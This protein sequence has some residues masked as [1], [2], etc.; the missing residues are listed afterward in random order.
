MTTE[1]AN[2]L[3]WNA[4]GVCFALSNELPKASFYYDLGLEAT[5]LYKGSDKKLAEAALLNNLGLIH[6]NLKK[7]NDAFLAFK[8][9]ETLS[10]DLFS[11]QLNLSQLFLE[12]KHDDKALVILNKLENI[13]PGDIDVLYSLAL[14]YSHQNEY[15]KALLTLSKI[16][17]EKL[18]RP[19]IAGTYAFDLL[20]TNQLTEAQAVMEKRL[21]SSPEGDYEQYNKRNKAL[22][23]EISMRIKELEA[24]TKQ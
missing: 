8:K 2:P 17:S 18:N 1:K 14:I 15:E 10:P 24:K 11:I 20:K 7:Y 9:A 12:F 6:L 19:D 22:E 4:L 16:K 23:K 13:R 3:Y 21:T 5:T